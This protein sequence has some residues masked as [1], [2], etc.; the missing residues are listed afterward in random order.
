[1]T[2]AITTH[3]HTRSPNGSAM[4]TRKGLMLALCDGRL[5]LCRGCEK[6]TSSGAGMGTIGNFKSDLAFAHLRREGMLANQ[7]R[8]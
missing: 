6:A 4:C 3:L 7:R 8:E 2:R 1:M 5:V